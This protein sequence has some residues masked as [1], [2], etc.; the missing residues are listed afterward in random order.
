MNKSIRVDLAG[1]TLLASRT[2]AQSTPSLS[3][4]VKTTPFRAVPEL[5]HRVVANFF[6]FPNGMVAEE[7]AGVAIRRDIFASTFSLAPH[8]LAA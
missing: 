7:A 2:G 1:L 8:Q 5:P 6:K 4:S 3:T